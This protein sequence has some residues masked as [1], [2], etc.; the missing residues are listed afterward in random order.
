M[1]TKLKLT[2]RNHYNKFMSNNDLTI[3]E[4]NI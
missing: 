2:D 3:F 4:K 1:L